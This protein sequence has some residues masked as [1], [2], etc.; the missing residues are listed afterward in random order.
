MRKTDERDMGG[1][2][3]ARKSGVFLAS[4]LIHSL[5]FI[6]VSIILKREFL[7]GFADAYVEDGFVAQLTFVQQAL[8]T[9]NSAAYQE[10]L[11]FVHVIR[12]LI[13][14][15]FLLRT[16]LGLPVFLDSVFLIG[17]LSPI[18]FASFGGRRY[19]RQHLFLYFGL[20]VSFRSML[21]ACAIGYLFLVLYSDVRSKRNFV[22]SSVLAYLSTASM[23]GWLFICVLFMRSLV[24]SLRSKT[25]VLVAI[26]FVVGGIGASALEKIR[27]FAE[28]G[29][30]YEAVVE[31]D[32]TAMRALSR[33]TIY[34]SIE[35]G[36]YVRALSYLA[37]V[38]AVAGLYA[39][40][41]FQKAYRRL[42][43]FFLAPLPL[44]AFEGL[45]PM[46]FLFPVCWVLFGVL[47]FRRSRI[48]RPKINRRVF[49]D[50]SLVVNQAK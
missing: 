5:I 30:G 23:V 12:L 45:G 38:G 29:A 18:L 31:T 42:H 46:A 3:P 9:G 25:I 49:S 36:N 4:A 34:V 15:P 35:E 1:R 39:R 10:P 20:L 13:A 33:N 27:G 24:H 43:W 6:F 2:T 47:Q 37:L 16:Q 40:T 26:L 32:S 41:L 21:V 28:G 44:F 48:R 8:F 17:F 7:P 14:L 50:S 22:M 19:C 11:F